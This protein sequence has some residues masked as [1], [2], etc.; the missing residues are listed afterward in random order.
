MSQI[1][2]E[3]DPMPADVPAI[4]AATLPMTVG[5]FT[6]HDE[7]MDARVITAT[8]ADAMLNRVFRNKF[9]DTV[10]ASLAV[11]TDY[12]LGIPH[13]PEECYPAPGGKSQVVV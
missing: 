13:A 7:P 11:W 8:Q 9:G 10:I 5:E 3:K 1:G 2:F 6:G 4:G 12:K